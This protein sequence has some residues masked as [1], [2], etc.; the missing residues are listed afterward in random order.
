M[1]FFTFYARYLGSEGQLASNVPIYVIT[2]QFEGVP[3]MFCVTLSGKGRYCHVLNNLRDANYRATVTVQNTVVICV[4]DQTRNC[5]QGLA[6]IWGSTVCWRA[7]SKNQPKMLQFFSQ[8]RFLMNCL[9][10][11]SWGE[12][13]ERRHRES[14]VFMQ[15]RPK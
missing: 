14:L 15:K 13:K 4:R 9:L 5:L 10:C 12:M 6:R 2:V 1:T 7:R 11:Q 8:S 3:E